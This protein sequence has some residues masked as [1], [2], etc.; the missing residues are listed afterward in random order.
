MYKLKFWVWLQAERFQK[1]K[2]HVAYVREK[3]VGNLQFIIRQVYP[4]IHPINVIT[5]QEGAK[6]PKQMQNRT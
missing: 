4:K 2:M 5:S 3:V 6:S 1:N